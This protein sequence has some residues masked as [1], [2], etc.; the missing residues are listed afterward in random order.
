MFSQDKRWKGQCW[1][2]V[3]P[4]AVSV[5]LQMYKEGAGKYSRATLNAWQCQAVG[6]CQGCLLPHSIVTTTA[7]GYNQHIDFMHICLNQTCNVYNVVCI[8]IGVYA[9]ARDQWKQKAQPQKFEMLYSRYQGCKDAREGKD[10]MR[11]KYRQCASL[12]ECSYS[13]M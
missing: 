9:V 8:W 1:W 10:G 4:S 2:L 6:I 13:H 12:Q 5:Y 11:C 3:V 7:E